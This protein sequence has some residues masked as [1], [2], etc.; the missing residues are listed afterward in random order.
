MARLLKYVIPTYGYI[1]LIKI[2]FPKTFVVTI[3]TFTG[4]AATL[5]KGKT[6]APPACTSLNWNEIVKTSV[7]VS[8]M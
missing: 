5:N 4:E 2:S 6:V 1:L 7:H 3:L 8:A